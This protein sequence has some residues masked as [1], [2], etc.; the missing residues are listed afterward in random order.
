MRKTV[1]EFVTQCQTCQKTKRNYH[2][3]VI[4]KTTIINQT[5]DNPP[6][7]VEPFSQI[8]MDYLELTPTE[9][10]NKCLLV[11]IDRSTRLVK[12]IP[13]KT[14]TAIEL[15]PVI[16]NEWIFN[17]GVP[18]IILSDNGG[19]FISALMNQLNKVLGIDGI[20]S[21]A[22]NPQ[23]HGL[24][25]RANQT[26]QR[27]MRSIIDTHH[28]AINKWE[29]YVNQVTFIMNTTVN[30]S[31]GFTPYELVYGRKACYPIDRLLY[32]DQVFKSA[33]DY[34]KQLINQQ[35]INYTVV[36]QHLLEK[37]EMDEIY[38]AD[39]KN[40]LRSYDIGNLVYKLQE[41]TRNKLE[42]LYDGPY[43]VM[44]KINDLCYQIKLADVE[45]SPLLLVNIRQLK[46]YIQNAEDGKSINEV[47]KEFKSI[48][49]ARKPIRLE[50]NA[51][52]DADFD[53]IYNDED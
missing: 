11:I 46:P 4:K 42:I 6:T 39:K 20:L 12:L 38:N 45:N 34:F 16:I 21:T 40:K 9:N 15:I 1:K 24:V 32:D 47:V 23:S 33:S 17:Y 49:T 51:M 19:S 18:R 10:G 13:C 26:V 37:K 31:T 28:D 22:Y 29:K 53:M 14:H 7:F 5:L 41:G 44:K 8:T 48:V 35:K 3:D 43:E 25:E 30:S 2:Q 52:S 36:H 50:D 27:I